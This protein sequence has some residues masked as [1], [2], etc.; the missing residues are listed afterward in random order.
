MV[1]VEKEGRI[2]PLDESSQPPQ[3]RKRYLHILIFFVVFVLAVY[4]FL[5]P[6]VKKGDPAPDFSLKDIDGEEVK[7][8][9][10]RGK[11]V[12][13]NFWA[14][15]CPP[16]LEEIPSINLLKERFNRDDFV[17]LAVNIDKTPGSEI[18]KFVKEKG[19]N[20]RVLLDPGEDVSAK[21][22][23]ITGVPETFLI[24]RDGRVVERYIGPRDWADE[25]FINEF[26]K[27]L[28][29]RKVN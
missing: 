13:L 4:I 25:K 24:D 23:G 29:S 22:Y 8:S 3:K 20:F 21:K 16:C 12:F 15:W 17:I 7:L 11:V 18:K 9:G 27:L 28:E 10:L 1:L 2:E 26:N 14:T 6:S 19:L 5:M